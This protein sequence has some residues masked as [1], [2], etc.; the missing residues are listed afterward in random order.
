MIKNP[1]KYKQIG[2]EIHKGVLLVG[3]PGCGKTMLAKAIANQAGVNFIAK[4]GS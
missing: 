1:K 2:A 4:S 3:P